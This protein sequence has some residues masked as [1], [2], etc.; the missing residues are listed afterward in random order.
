[1]NPTTD[2]AL[3]S[4]LPVPPESHFPIQNL[5]YGVFRRRSGGAASVGVAIGEN[6]LDLAVVDE[7]G[8]L[9]I[10]LLRGQ[11]MFAAGKLN[12]FLA[13]GRTIWSETRAVISRLLQ[14]EEPS[15][16]DNARVREQALVPQRDVEML[17]PADIGDYTDFYSSREH[18]TNVGTMLRGADHA[19]QANWLHLPVAYHGRSSSLVVTGT[20]V[21]RPCGQSKPE[22]ADAPVFGPSRSLDFELEMGVI[23][24]PGN[25]LG[26]P[27]PVTTAGQHLFGL[28]LLNDWSARD[29]QAW[30]YVPL[31]PFLAKN[32][33]TTLSPW[34]VPLEALQPWRTSGPVQNPTPLPYLQTA[35]PEAYDIHLEVHLQS[36][37]MAEPQRICAS[38]FRYL[39][40]S[41]AQ[42]LAHHTSNGC[43]M[44]PGDLLGSGTISGRAPD[45]YGSMLELAWRGT[46]PLTLTS[47]EQRNF[48]QNGDKVILTGW[49]QGDGYRVGFGE[50]A[51]TILP[52]L[53]QQE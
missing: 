26:Q 12:P 18:A 23:L 44:R 7:A 11:Y 15:L 45:S 17:L 31:G 24:G 48:L 5:P 3:R 38:N 20:P 36:A 22:K 33:C 1:M 53:E 35:G 37:R 52:A 16:R 32:F 34:V 9:P 25:E 14:G 43:N 4:W 39:Y 2:P 42:Q 29:I 30:E 51:G 47:G 41:L 10:S 40:W 50:A 27:I 21:R 49:C 46:R 13:L 19:L 8:L 6:V 28:M